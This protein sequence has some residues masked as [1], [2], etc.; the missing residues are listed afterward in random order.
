MNV[1]PDFPSMNETDVRETIVRP[2]IE[3]LGYKHGT[4]ANIRT[5]Q[6]LRYGKAFLGRKNPAKDPDL[7]GKAD[8]ICEVIS[9][10]RWIV[11][12]KAAG[13]A[14]SRD[15]IE[16][17]HTYAAH[18]EVAATHFIVTNGREFR[19]FQTSLLEHPLLT[20][21]YHE[22]QANHLR[23]LNLLGPEAVRARARAN[24][25]DPGE[26]LGKGLASRLSVS[27]G[28]IH[29][30]EHFGDNPFV[31]SSS[32]NG[33]KLPVIGGYVHRTDDNRIFGRVELA[34]AAALF[35]MD[36]DIFNTSEFIS[37]AKYISHDPEH[38]TIFQ[39]IKSVTVP[40]GFE[41]NIPGTGKVPTP[42]EYSIK[43][44]TEAV[45]FVDQGSFCGTMRLAYDFDFSKMGPEVRR[46]FEPRYG[47]IPD[48]CHVDGL[49]RFEI[50]LRA[51]LVKL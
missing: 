24:L 9:F 46:M 10:G 12:V 32:L 36:A 25:P 8:Y 2:L 37:A 43:T 30:E 1:L 27:G 19:L 3:S 48:H 34:N 14:I 17:A 40:A 51:G 35:L 5:E 29:L 16:Q 38:P 47:L 26:P 31:P 6:R 42:F 41:I 33:L 18:P 23:L 28:M 13:K 49:G 7:V 15:D 44:F 45:G 21:E 20:W 22:A 4:E 39:G 11:E 50:G